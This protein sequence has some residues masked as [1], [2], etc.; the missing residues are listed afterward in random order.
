MSSMSNSVDGKDVKHVQTQQSI[1]SDVSSVQLTTQL[2]ESSVQDSAKLDSTNMFHWCPPQ[3]LS[4]C[5]LVSLL[6]PKK[7]S[8]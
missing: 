2:V 7:L 5:L 8:E 6:P 4:T 3:S 1:Y